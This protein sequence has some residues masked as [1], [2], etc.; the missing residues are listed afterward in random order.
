MTL[1]PALLAAKLL[2]LSLMTASV[3]AFAQ[4]PQPDEAESVNFV[5]PPGPG[6]RSRPRSSAN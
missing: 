4:S 1:R 6:S 2:P 3:A 5:V